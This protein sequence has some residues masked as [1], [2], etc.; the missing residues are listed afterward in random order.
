[1][2]NANRVEIDA[3]LPPGAL[4]LFQ[5]GE[6]SSFDLSAEWSQLLAK[7]AVPNSLS[8]CF[9]LIQHEGGVKGVL[10]LLLPANHDSA[11]QV[12]GFT[13]FYTSVFRPL[14]KDELTADE[15]ASPIRQIV[16]ETCASTLRFDAMDPKHRSFA[17]LREALRKA[18]LMPFEFFHF[19]NWYLPVLGRSYEQYFSELSSQ[20]QNTVKRRGKKFIAS[21][22]GQLE[23]VTVG[24]RLEGAIKAWSQIYQ[25]SWK[26]PEPYPEFMPGLIRLCARQG[27]LRLGLAYY[28]GQP[29]AAQV[30][31][32]SHGR[33][34]IYKLAYDEAHSHHSAGTLLTAHLMRHVLDVDK[35]SEVDYLI[36]DDAYKKDWVN[37]RRERW[38]IVA[39]N[40]R[41]VRG[42]IG[43]G[44]QRLGR[45]KR[46]FA[47]YAANFNLRKK[48][49]EHVN[50]RP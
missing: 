8:P 14:L 24:E 11:A 31:I 16:D 29:I 38:G 23:I 20:V 21:G 17:L 49:N 41:S 9:Y 22:R 36:G 3:S 4:S 2:S 1:M 25:S 39:Y 33:A 5:S 47:A 46:F 18:G 50:A 32:V 28:D 15:L 30:W 48:R 12:L 6:Q 45:L 26:V 35:V 40:L 43:Y 37:Q 34:A 13:N 42:V 7:T 19:G 44:K 27:W 10:P